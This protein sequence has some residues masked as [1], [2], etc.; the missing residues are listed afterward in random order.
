M[1]SIARIP[2]VLAMAALAAE[3]GPRQ[4]QPAGFPGLSVAVVCKSGDMGE[5]SD[6]AGRYPGERA[7]PQSGWGNRSERKSGERPLACV[8]AGAESYRVFVSAA[9]GPLD[10]TMGV[11]R[12]MGSTRIWSVIRNRHDGRLVERS[13]GVLTDQDWRQLSDALLRFGFWQQPTVLPPS[14][15]SSRM[16]GGIFS[17]EGHLSKRYHVVTREAHDA[18]MTNLVKVFIDLAREKSTPRPQTPRVK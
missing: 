6:T 12:S 10:T 17:V 3:C 18:S 9:A 15:D 4:E 1:K 14:P 7:D 13:E 2:Y 5:Y 16:D 8:D 11:S